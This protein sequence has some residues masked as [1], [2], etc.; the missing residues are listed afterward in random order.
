VFQS[1][2]ALP[3]QAIFVLLNEKDKKVYISYSTKF[4][5]KLGSIAEQIHDHT[6]RWK[7]MI[8]D[9]KKL[10]LQILETSVQKNFVKYYRDYYRNKGYEL[11]NEKERIPLWY[12]FKLGYTQRKV[13]VFAVDGHWN[14]TVLGRFDTYEEARGFLFYI[15]HNNPAHSLCYSIKGNL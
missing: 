7:D 12:E 3:K 9:K 15:R 8:K 13:V 6:W 4:H 11:Y 5:S 14:K 1:I 10:Q 2:L